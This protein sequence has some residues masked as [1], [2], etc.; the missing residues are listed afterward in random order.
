MLHTGMSK[1]MQCRCL[2]AHSQT[3]IAAKCS[4]AGTT[5]CS[6]LFYSKESCHC[7][8]YNAETWLQE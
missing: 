1:H 8:R 3:L 5:I 7:R 4:F 6:L 2:V